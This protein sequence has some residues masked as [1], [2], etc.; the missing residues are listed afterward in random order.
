MLRENKGKNHQ[1]AEFMGFQRWALIT[2]I[3]K[4]VSGFKINYLEQLS[5]LGDEYFQNSMLSC[6]FQLVSNISKQCLSDL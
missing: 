3:E 4:V 5:C 2:N 6:T 1:Y